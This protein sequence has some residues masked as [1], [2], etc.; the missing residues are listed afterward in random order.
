MRN[1]TYAFF[2]S[3]LGL[4][5]LSWPA[6]ADPPDADDPR[7]GPEIVRICFSFAIDNWS[8]VDGL[9]NAVILRRGV[10]EWFFLD[11]IGAC[12]S[13]TLR[14]AMQIGIEGDPNSNCV[15]RGDVLLVQ[16]RGSIARRCAVN[17]IYEWSDDP[18]SS[19][20]A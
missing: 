12:S 2:I 19:D 18:Q 16:E 4:F 20:D 15:S 14:S 11:L 10:D 5:F 1:R 3:L 6:S 17:H 13:S 9:D 8:T 7:A